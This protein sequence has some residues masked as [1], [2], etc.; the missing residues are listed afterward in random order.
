[1]MK[2]TCVIPLAVVLLSALG[3][4]HEAVA[5]GRLDV[6][7]RTVSLSYPELTTVHLTFSPSTAPASVV[8]TTPDGSRALVFLHLLD[9]KGAVVR[10]FDRP[11]RSSEDARLYQSALAPPLDPGKY[12]LSIGIY[13]HSG[14]RFALTGLGEPIGRNEYL[15]ADV[16]VPPQAAGPRF[17]FSS[18]WEPIEAGTDK[19]VVARR[20]LS[21]QPGD[22]RVDAIPAAGSLWL[23]FRIPPGSGTGEKLVLHDPGANTPA[24]VVRGTCGTVETGFSGPGFHA[25][26]IAVDGATAKNGCQLTLTPNFHI[27]STN[28]TELRSV[29]L[30]VASWIPAGSRAAS[31]GATGDSN[32]DHGDPTDPG[33]H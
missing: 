31:S 1:M 16:E 6:Q 24:A 32:G 3:C 2:K 12:R 27:T 29:S 28:R 4:K 9:A 18:A 23:R 8:G 10:T 17:S 33:S 7:P 14:K 13:D 20:W 15:A 30:D 26:E 25:V 11:L 5:V 19:Q 21:D 22:I